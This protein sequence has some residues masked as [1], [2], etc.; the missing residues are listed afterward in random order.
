[1]GFVYR[2]RNAPCIW[3][4]PARTRLDELLALDVVAC[5]LRPLEPCKPSKIFIS[6]FTASS[7]TLGSSQGDVY[8]GG[9]G[10]D[11]LGQIRATASVAPFIK[12]CGRLEFSRCSSAWLPAALSVLLSRPHWCPTHLWLGLR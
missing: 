7:D 3:C 5:R 1:M 8:V 2:Q 4:S 12:R 10:V 9:S 6:L 11:R